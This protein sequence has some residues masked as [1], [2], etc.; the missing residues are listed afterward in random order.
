MHSDPPQ[1]EII[2]EAAATEEAAEEDGVETKDQLHNTMTVA[3]GKSRLVKDPIHGKTY[4]RQKARTN[5][6]LKLLDSTS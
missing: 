4:I 6:N 3:H 5:D 1:N 2:L